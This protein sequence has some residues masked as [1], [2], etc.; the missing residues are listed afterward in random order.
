MPLF[1]GL[2]LIH[3]PINITK[4]LGINKGFLTGVIFAAFF[5]ELYFRGVFFGQLFRYAKIGF[6]PSI[7]L[8][9]LLFASGHLWQSSD[10]SV[11]VGIFAT[12]FLGALFFAWTYIEWNNNLWVPIGL[13]LF[14]NL[15]WMLF[16]VGDNALGDAYAN[17]FRAITIAFTIVGTL[18]YKKHNKAGLKITRNNLWINKNWTDPANNV[19]LK[20]EIS[21]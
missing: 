18:L 3:K 15:H 13:H 4:S 14:M 16:S 11:L 21:E 2:F 12:T 9:A 10:L 5:E 19:N 1:I 20:Q 7:L 6:I 17:I 8:C